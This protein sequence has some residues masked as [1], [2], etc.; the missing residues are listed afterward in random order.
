MKTFLLPVLSFCLL[1]C[2]GCTHFTV[3]GDGTKGECDSGTVHGS[4]YG[5]NWSH[6]EPSKSKDDLGLYRVDYHTNMLYSLA[7]VC[8]LGL[9]VPQD[10]QWWIQEKQQSTDAPVWNPNTPILKPKK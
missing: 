1:V 3:E 4:F 8:S 6:W 9:Y 5:F 10:A 2:A 7:A